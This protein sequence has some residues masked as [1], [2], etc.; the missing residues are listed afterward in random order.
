MNIICPHCHISIDLVLKKGLAEVVCPSCGSSF[1]LYDEETLTFREAPPEK[2][3]KFELKDHLGTGRF[4][5]VYRAHDTVLGRDVVIKL[6]RRGEID[7]TQTGLFLREARAAGQLQH[8]NIV[9]VHDVGIEGDLVYIVSELID[10]V[11][12]REWLSR[13]KPTF[14]QAAQFCA[15]IAGALQ[16][17][18]THQIV[19]RDLKPSNVLIDG[20][21]KLYL[22]DFGLSRRESAEYTITV[23]GKIIGTPAYMSPEQARGDGHATDARSDIYSLGT[24]LYEMLTGRRPFD[25]GNKQLLLQQVQFADPPRPRS[26]NRAI[27]RDLETICLAALEKD[28]AK[29]YQTAEEMREDLRRYLEGLPI[30]RRPIGLPVR[31]W[32]WIRRNPA[33]ATSMTVAC[34]ALAGVTG[35][36]VMRPPSVDPESRWVDIAADQADATVVFMPLRSIDGRPRAEAKIVSV[37]AGTAPV[38]LR[39][40]PG[41][42]WV[43]AHSPDRR[44]FHEVLRTVPARD[45]PSTGGNYRHRGWTT[46]PDGSVKL[47]AVQLF[48]NEAVLASKVPMAVVEGRGDVQLGESPEQDFAGF[49]CQIPTFFL[50]AHKVTARDWR[51]TWYALPDP[52]NR[53]PPE[54]LDTPLT[55]I[56]YDKMLDHAEALGK[57]LLDEAELEFAQTDRGTIRID[58]ARHAQDALD[59]RTTADVIEY[60]VPVSGLRTDPLE[61]TSTWF[62]IYMPSEKATHSAPEAVRVVR[63]G[64]VKDEDPKGTGGTWRRQPFLLNSNDPAVGFR[65]ARSEKPRLKADDFPRLGNLPLR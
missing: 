50:D 4:G 62:Y 49:S 10:G 22:T 32:R 31:T 65:C 54:N 43:V 6:P 39:L 20:S 51:N 19:H 44:A 21:N 35:M 29:R 55:N 9:K 13:H 34:V 12:L 5:D 23:Q 37:M 11:N 59:A 33:V 8:D 1:S 58:D 27:P 14:A 28:P 2:I 60:S 48:T 30:K 15:V 45:A 41:E 17:A 24:M 56:I 7:A 52:V 16:H 63:G 36:A 26:I 64:L 18:H 3:G 47:P 61:A 40:R 38:R 46:Q 42:Y 25:G 53:N 57:R